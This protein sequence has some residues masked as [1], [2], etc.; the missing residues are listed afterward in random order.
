MKSEE[1]LWGFNFWLSWIAPRTSLMFDEQHSQTAKKLSGWLSLH[2]RAGLR[3]QASKFAATCLFA[4]TGRKVNKKRTALCSHERTLTQHKASRLFVTHSV[5]LKGSRWAAP[6]RQ[7][8][9]STSAKASR[10]KSCYWRI[11]KAKLNTAVV[12]TLW[13]SSTTRISQALTAEELQ[14]SSLTLQF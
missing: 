8:F 4:L 13:F 2:D 7:K 11:L 5:P 9:L 14:I 12:A 10:V 6:S 3:Q 1:L